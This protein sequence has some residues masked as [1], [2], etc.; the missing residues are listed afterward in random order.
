[1]QAASS[2]GQ[3]GASEHRHRAVLPLPLAFPSASVPSSASNSSHLQ[4]GALDPQA[5]RQEEPSLPSSTL[6][7]GSR[8]RSWAVHTCNRRC[9][10]HCL[11]QTGSLSTCTTIW[12]SRSSC[13]PVPHS[14]V[15]VVGEADCSSASALAHALAFDW[16]PALRHWRLL[17]NFGTGRAPDIHLPPSTQSPSEPPA[18]RESGP[19]PIA[20]FQPLVS[21]PIA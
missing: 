17:E 20:M 1:M 3:Q 21:F 14:L 2:V 11:L 4:V 15:V 7:G 6:A 8:R 10:V 13:G 12:T 19:A 16:D 18:G 5:C 9:C